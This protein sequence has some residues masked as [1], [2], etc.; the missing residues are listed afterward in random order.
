MRQLTLYKGQLAVKQ[1][2]NLQLDHSNSTAMDKQILT[3]SGTGSVYHYYFADIRYGITDFL[4]I[5]AETNLS[6][7]A[8]VTRQLHMSPQLPPE[9]KA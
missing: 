7:M 3:N 6:V 2:I 4:E 5:G 9:R 1:A 8:C